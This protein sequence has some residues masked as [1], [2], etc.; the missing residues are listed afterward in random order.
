MCNRSQLCQSFCKLLP[1]PQPR[2][3]HTRPHFSP[4][5][6]ATLPLLCPALLCLLPQGSFALHWPLINSDHL[7]ERLAK[8]EL[9]SKRLEDAKK[10]QLTDPNFRCGRV[11]KREWG[12][13]LPSAHQHMHLTCTSCTVWLTYRMFISC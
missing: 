6:A 7:R 4:P 2:P 10:L 8:R 9:E 12:E 3:E 11:R 1:H 13:E 5:C